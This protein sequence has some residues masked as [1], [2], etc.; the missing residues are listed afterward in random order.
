MSDPA[1]PARARSRSGDS[2]PAF[3]DAAFPDAAALALVRTALDED[4]GPDDLDVTTLATFDPGATTAAT[5]V[6]RASGEEDEVITARIDLGMGQTFR[7]HVFNSA[8]HRSPQH[9][10][11]IVERTGAGEPLPRPDAA[12]K[13]QATP[14]ATGLPVSLPKAKPAGPYTYKAYGEK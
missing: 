7:D 9:Y 4:L 12:P 3:P 14:A 10:R 13:S 6:A 2:G 5:L 1:L 11:L 8:K